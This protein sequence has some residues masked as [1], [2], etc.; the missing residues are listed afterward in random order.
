LCSALDRTAYAPLVVLGE[1]GP[2]AAKLRDRGVEVVVEPFPAPPLHQLVRPRILWRELRAAL[3]L[4]RLARA[5]AAA[6]LPCGGL[7]ALPSPP[8][9]PAPRP[10][11]PPA[12]STR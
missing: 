6:L 12:S 9:S 11:A 5:R 4:R 10:S 1:D 8:S 7:L 2:L 3:R